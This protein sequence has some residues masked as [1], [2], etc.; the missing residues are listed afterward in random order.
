MANQQTIGSSSTV[1]TQTGFFAESTL[2]GATNNYG[3]R[4]NITAAANNYNLYMAG[5]AN[6]YMAGSLGIGTTSLT[7]ITLAIGKNITGAVTSYGAFQTGLVLSDVT[8]SARYYATSASTT[9]TT[10]TLTDLIHYYSAQGTFGAGSTVTNQYG[11][12]AQ[13]SLTGATNNYGFYGNLA[14]ASNVWNLYMNGTANNYLAGALG[15]GTTTLTGINLNVTKT[16]TGA[17]TSYG[18][19]QIGTVQSDVTSEGYGFFNATNTQATAFTLP[20]YYGFMASQS[21]IGAG[22]VITNQFGFYANS[23]LAGAANNYGFYGAVVVS[24]SSNWN[25]YMNGTAP[26][27]LQGALGIGNTSLTQI[28]LRLGKT[29]TG[30]TTSYGILNGGIIQSDVTTIGTYNRTSASTAATTFTLTD[31]EHYGATQG[32][33]GAGST[34]TN[35]YGF[36]AESSLT[37]ATNNY[38]FYGNI[39]SGTNRWNLYMAGTA[40]NY[41]AGSLGIGSNS[42]NASAALQVT[43]T[44]QG[45]LFPV[46]TAAQRTAISSPANGLIVTQSDGTAGIYIYL[47]SAWHAIAML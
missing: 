9:A 40:Q 37:G 46:M 2:S 32:T 38:G 30:A 5:T 16:I 6:N 19:R 20:N 17:T 26:N 11:F 36:R 42:I 25:L 31:L 29:I 39:A 23:A 18:I 10:F 43:S 33:I 41:L 13:S 3:F 1:T 45:V 12:Y 22:S 21:T 28:T 4:G 47:N 35:Q 15:I 8:T 44:T 34:V 7:G 27:F 24:G 14:A